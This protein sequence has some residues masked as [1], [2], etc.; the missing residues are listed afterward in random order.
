MYLTLK[1]FVRAIFKS[2]MIVLIILFMV[3]LLDKN[4]SFANYLCKKME[5][6][7]D[8]SLTVMSFGFANEVILLSSVFELGIILYIYFKIINNRQVMNLYY[9]LMY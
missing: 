7:R 1:D 5:I 6:P 4:I 9:K 8:L 2:F 3:F